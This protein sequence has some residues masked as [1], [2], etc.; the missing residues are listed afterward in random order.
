MFARGKHFAL[1]IDYN[2]IEWKVKKKVISLME[3][4]MEV[5]EE[6]VEHIV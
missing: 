4:E 5:M 2:P 6:D 1:V 3:V